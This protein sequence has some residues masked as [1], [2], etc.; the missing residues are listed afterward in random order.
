MSDEYADGFEAG[1]ESKQEEIDSLKAEA[2][3]FAE[4]FA[5]ADNK[6]QAAETKLEAMREQLTEIEIKHGLYGTPITIDMY[7]TEL[8]V[9]GDLAEALVRKLRDQLEE[10]IE[11][12]PEG[13]CMECLNKIREVIADSPKPDDHR[14][15]EW[16]QV[17]ESGL[18]YR[19]VSMTDALDK[20][21]EYRKR[22]KQAAGERNEARK[23]YQFMVDR[24]ADE[25]LDGYRELG[26]KA[27]QAEEER[28]EMQESFQ[29]YGKQSQKE[30]AEVQ[31][32]LSKTA[33][34]LCME[35]ADK[36]KA[37]ADR[38]MKAL[39]EIIVIAL[40][41]E[42]YEMHPS[43]ALGKVY[44]IAAKTLKTQTPDTPDIAAQK[45]GMRCCERCEEVQPCVPKDCTAWKNEIAKLESGMPDHLKPAKE[46]DAPKGWTLCDSCQGEKY[47]GSDGSACH[48]VKVGP[49]PGFM[50]IPEFLC[51]VCGARYN[52][53]GPCPKCGVNPDAY[54]IASN[55]KECP[56]H[57]SHCDAETGQLEC[58]DCGFTLNT[59]IKGGE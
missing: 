56:H 27:A 23:N 3:K 45:D 33:Y 35:D 28:D 4:D 34:C 15:L 19:P 9:R 59:Q 41:P 52:I 24:A 50:R 49:H 57:N 36:L 2:K 8:E 5:D 13:M 47:Y 14:D 54:K 17:I 37:K 31:I 42:S 16:F 29:E 32:E 46:E 39:D 40:N 25:H 10:V 51:L 12:D 48:C 58:I 38:Y 18:G 1:E 30:L 55:S 11:C 22:F 53:S 43:A 20:L 44:C 6:W 26:A 7:I 21:I